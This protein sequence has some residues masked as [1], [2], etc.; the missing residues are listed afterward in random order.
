MVGG[1]CLPI[2]VLEGN[3]AFSVAGGRLLHGEEI[4]ER[5][6][7]PLHR[8][9]VAIVVSTL[10]SLLLL[11]LLVRACPM[12]SQ[13]DPLTRPLFPGWGVGLFWVGHLLC[14]ILP[15]PEALCCCWMI[16]LET[17]SSDMKSTATLTPHI[18]GLLS[19]P[20]LAC[21]AWSLL[22]NCT[23]AVSVSGWRDTDSTRPNS[24]HTSLNDASS[25]WR[26][27]GGH[28]V[29]IHATVCRGGNVTCQV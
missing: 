26:Y 23:T 10:P 28:R 5:K 7:F 18:T 29:V 27:T 20:A 1:S 12:L 15:W 19:N 13:W 14:C 4:P 6:L 9:V 17:W 24:L 2:P 21:M 22:E 8:V 3:G 16:K 25:T 11:L